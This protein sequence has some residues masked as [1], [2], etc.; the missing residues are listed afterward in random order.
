MIDAIIHG[1]AKV[2]MTIPGIN[3]AFTDVPSSLNQF[4]CFL[5]YPSTGDIEFPRQMNVRSTTHTVNIDLLVQKGGDLSAADRLCKPYIAKTVQVF[6]QN[7]TLFNS[8]LIAGIN[9]YDYG[10]IEYAGVQ[11]IGIK[12][13]L[14]A[15]EKE[16]V[17]YRG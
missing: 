11:Y 7:V 12:F 4:P 2:E 13:T 6:D 14:K 1:T 8:C 10:V 15:I 17:V 16:Q 3:G 9:H 5:N